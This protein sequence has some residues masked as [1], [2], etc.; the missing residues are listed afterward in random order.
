MHVGGA[1]AAPVWFVERRDAAT[2]SDL[3]RRLR[4]DV[5]GGLGGDA[6]RRWRVT[7]DLRRER[8]VLE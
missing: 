6:L 5:V 3:T 7:F 2:F 1:E 8:L 4:T